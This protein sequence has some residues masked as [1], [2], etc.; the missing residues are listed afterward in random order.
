M[1]ASKMSCMP[2]LETMGSVYGIVRSYVKS[3]VTSRSIHDTQGLD[4]C[5]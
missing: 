4:L 1:I 3:F 5:C 2:L